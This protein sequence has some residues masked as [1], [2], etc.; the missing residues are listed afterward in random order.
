MDKIDSEIKI[1]SETTNPIVFRRKFLILLEELA[2][3]DSIWYEFQDEYQNI[4][5]GTVRLHS[6]L[7]IPMS[8]FPSKHLSS[9]PMNDTISVRARRENRLRPHF[10]QSQNAISIDEFPLASEIKSQF[11]H[12]IQFLKEAPIKY[13]Q[14]VKVHLQLMITRKNEIFDKFRAMLNEIPPAPLTEFS[15]Y[16][17]ELIVINNRYKFLK[18]PL[19]DPSITTSYRAFTTAFDRINKGQDKLKLFTPKRFPLIP[20]MV[21]DEELK[22][23]HTA[24]RKNDN[25][26]A[27]IKKQIIAYA[28]AASVEPQVLQILLQMDPGFPVY[29]PRLAELVGSELNL[30][31]QA[32]RY[33][34]QRNI[35]LGKYDRM[36]QMFKFNDPK[37]ATKQLKSIINLYGERSYDEIFSAVERD[38]YYSSH[39]MKSLIV[40]I[41]QQIETL[42]KSSLDNN[43]RLDMN[44]LLDIAYEKNLLSREELNQLHVFRKLRNEITHKGRDDFPRNDVLNA[45][46]ILKR[47]QH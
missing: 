8:N 19:L 22:S 21:N 34:L 41:H 27:M 35:E 18:R 11:D 45:Y 16:L 10:E 43:Q 30:T 40:N 33:V 29:L 26:F 39:E 37:E 5:K 17:E 44:V 36:S 9:L 6:Q 47:L 13:V 38:E 3:L 31:E 28:E 1:A 2:F 25:K 23:L 32:L 15:P 7:K 4:R 14:L 20:E 12:L 24:F 42:L 46:H